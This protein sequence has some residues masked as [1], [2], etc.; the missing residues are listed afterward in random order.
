MIDLL[1]V[2]ASLAYRFI[3]FEKANGNPE[4]SREKL[5]DIVKQVSEISIVEGVDQLKLYEKLDAELGIGKGSMTSVSVKLEPWLANER[6][7]IDFMLWKR[8]KS[9]TERTDSAFPINDLDDYTNRILD[10]CVNP[11]QVGS[12][13]R[14]GMVVG[15]VQ[16]GKTSNFVGLINKATDAGYKL[17]I[18]VAGT[19]NSLRR[20]TQQRVDAG[21]I[22][23]NTSKG[24]KVGVGE[25][26]TDIQIYPLTS[27]SDIPDG[28]FE[29]SIARKKA[30]PL[31]KNPVVLVVKKNKGILENLID[32]LASNTMTKSDGTDYKL[33]D[34]PTLIIDDEADSASV[35]SV[36]KKKL[37]REQAMEEAKAINR[38]MR[39]LVSV[40]EK[41]TFIGYTATPYAN[42]FI[43]NDWK[44][45][46]TSVVR[47]REM[48]VG[49][50]LFPKDFILN[51]NARKNYIGAAAIFGLDG[52]G[53][54]DGIK[55]LDVIRY[56]DMSQTP[57]VYQDGEDADGEPVWKTPKKMDDLPSELPRSMKEAIKAFMLTCAIRRLRGH[58]NKHNSML[59]HAM[60][61]VR[62]IDWLAFLV[63]EE[64]RAYVDYIRGNDK[65]FLDELEQIFENDF[66]PTTKN[67]L[68]NLQY[69][70]VRIGPHDWQ[71][72]KGALIA[73]V[74]KIE[75]RAVHGIKATSKLEYK[76]IEEINYEPYDKVGLSVI[77]VGG[78][79]LARGITLE[80]LSV[81]YYLRASKMYDTLMQMG[82][83]FGYRPGYVDL[84]R[85]YTTETIAEWFSHITM[86]TEEMRRDF[87]IL[88]SQIDRVPA[89]FQLKVQNH[90][91]LLSITAAS[92]LFWAEQLSLSFSGQNP[93][94]YKLFTDR[95]NVKANFKYFRELM[96][97]LGIPKEDQKIRLESTGNL[98]HLLY[99]DVDEQLLCE[100]LD[101][102]RIDQPSIKNA[103]LSSYIRKQKSSGNI[104]KW[105]VAV[106]SN[107]SEQVFINLTGD[108]KASRKPNRDVMSVQFFDGLVNI[109]ATVRNQTSGR[110]SD[111]YMIAKNQ[112]DEL[113]DRKVDLQTEVADNNAAIKELREQVRE[114][115]I[116]FYLLDPRAT[117]KAEHDV[118]IVGYSIHFPRITDEEMVSYMVTTND[119]VTDDD[120]DDDDDERGEAGL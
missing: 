20:Q 5:L 34:V 84:V 19:M 33:C 14:R 8:F 38:L 75:V 23:V 73:A 67:V 45:D 97:S 37:T 79:R 57:F 17:I 2:A 102:Y 76:N 43:P 112:I 56:V 101:A 105:N 60:L 61:Y 119:S 22:G 93:Q 91:G 25:I 44:K 110:Q 7:N 27:S 13:D 74:S 88:A 35:N 4:I 53:A 1:E 77:A 118:P 31:G 63:N 9:F 30:I 10:K 115:L 103:T 54:E 78:S 59:I 69:K 3:D 28:D 41:V 65:A 107:T 21:Y 104:L 15:H 29:Q 80:G 52:E 18:I 106:K 86:A 24:T 120:D 58:E 83:W 42:L 66:K 26:R 71:E 39:T 48:K 32:W 82:R 95:K 50:D 47:G 99:R 64:L 40:F 85:L 55:P 114:G 6:A 51:I 16:S 11:K 89:D 96:G 90:S 68:E 92:K 116:V 117:A 98:S 111:S 100:F 12:W 72:V 94:T 70:D 109:G 87:D 81:S 46:L 62:W 113:K 108:K 36:S 49:P